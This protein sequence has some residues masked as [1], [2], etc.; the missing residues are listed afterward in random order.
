MNSE[1]GRRRFGLPD[2]LFLGGRGSWARSQD[3]VDDVPQRVAVGA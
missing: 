1:L 2:S 3:E